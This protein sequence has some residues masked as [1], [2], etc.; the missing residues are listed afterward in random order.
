MSKSTCS[1][2]NMGREKKLESPRILALLFT[3]RRIST[4]VDSTRVEVDFRCKWA[5]V[6]VPQMPHR[7]IYQRTRTALFLNEECR[8]S[9]HGLCSNY[10]QQTSRIQAWTEFLRSHSFRNISFP[11]SRLRITQRIVFKVRYLGRQLRGRNAIKTWV[12]PWKFPT[13]I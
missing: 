9:R 5:E 3:C 4:H 7:H 12:F 11:I 10:Q 1:T 8:A 13:I 2:D 6:P